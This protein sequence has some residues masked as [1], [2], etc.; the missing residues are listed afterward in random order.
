MYKHLA[1]AVLAFSV[2]VAIVVDDFVTPSG[3]EI[4]AEKVKEE[5]AKPKKQVAAAD[6]YA[7]DYSDD[8]EEDDGYYDDDEDLRDSSSANSSSSRNSNVEIAE[9]DEETEVDIIVDEP[10]RATPRRSNEPQRTGGL[11]LP[12]DLGS[13]EGVPA[14]AQ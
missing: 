4:T 11:A 1:F 8:Y 12:D 13:A 9:N 14:E 10:R 7:D 2:V 6:P 3:E 5:A